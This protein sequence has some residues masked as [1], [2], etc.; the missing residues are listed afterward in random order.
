MDAKSFW[1]RI[2][3]TSLAIAIVGA[4]VAAAPATDA[5]LQK[6]IAGAR[7]VPP[8]SIAYDRS[9]RTTAREN[10]GASETHVQVDRWDG[11]Q[12]LRI[13]TDGKPATPDE[14]AKANKTSAGLPVAGYHRV[15]DLLASGARRTGE[16]AGQVTYH[17]DRLPKGSVN[18]GGDRSADMAGDATIDT[19]GPQPFVSRIHFFL[20]KPLSIMFVAKLDKF[21]SV[22]DYRIGADGRPVLVHQ[23]RTIVGSQFGTAG[24][25]RTES[26]YTPLR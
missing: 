10:G 25:T 2:I 15:A 11:R 7:A 12:M 17:I 24:E 26:T 4:P 18:I 3:L 6:V 9:S 21:D 1:M 20:H 5:L 8:A 22:N 14:I 23:L 19:T 13:S 16:A